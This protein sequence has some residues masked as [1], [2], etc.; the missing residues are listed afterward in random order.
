MQSAPVKQQA[1]YNSQCDKAWTSVTKQ[2]IR[3]ISKVIVSIFF[4]MLGDMEVLSLLYAGKKYSLSRMAR[5]SHANSNQK[6]LNWNSIESFQWTLIQL[7]AMPIL[8]IVRIEEFIHWLCFA[9]LSKFWRILFFI[10]LQWY[11]SAYLEFVRLL[12]RC[13]SVE[14]LKK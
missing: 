8:S 13:I 4:I 12:D 7:R 6:I 10:A 9:F 2:T 5:R 11:C 3:S 14:P 1:Q